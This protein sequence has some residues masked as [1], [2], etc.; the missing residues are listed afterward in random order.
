MQTRTKRIA[1]DVLVLLGF[2]GAF[3]LFISIVNNLESSETD[4]PNDFSVHRVRADEFKKQKDWDAAKEHLKSLIA[5]DPFD[6]RA[7][8]EYAATLYKQRSI[9]IDEYDDLVDLNRHESDEGTELLKKIE[10]YNNLSTNELIKAKAFARY[11]GRALLFL[12]V[13]QAEREDWEQ[14][15]NFLEEFVDSGNYT[16]D[17]LREARVFGSGGEDMTDFDAKITGDTKLHADSR[18]WDICRREKANRA[19]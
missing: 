3:F 4:D 10:D 2:C 16:Y 6:G 19:Y 12:A 8:F 18:F 15:L 5:R 9:L 13:V 7:Q 11:R 1:R 14:T 17:G